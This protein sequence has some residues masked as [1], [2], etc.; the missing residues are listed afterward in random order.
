MMP[1][2]THYLW[3]K[4]EDLTKSSSSDNSIGPCEETS[5]SESDESDES[6]ELEDEDMEALLVRHRDCLNCACIK[7]NI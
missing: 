5:I 3:I 1:M 2:N 6:D 4:F 7:E